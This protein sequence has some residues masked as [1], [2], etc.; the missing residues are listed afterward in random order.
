EFAAPPTTETVLS[1]AF[2]TLAVGVVVAAACGVG[3]SVGVRVGV[4][5]GVAVVV[6]VGTGAAW[7]PIAMLIAPPPTL[8]PIGVGV[9]SLVEKYMT[10]LGSLLVTKAVA[11]S[12]VNA[13]PLGA[14]PGTLMW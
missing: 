9:V 11:P 1:A 7:R 5:V 8:M 12:G 4:D 6:G 10:A 14:P 2:V 13:M 3:V